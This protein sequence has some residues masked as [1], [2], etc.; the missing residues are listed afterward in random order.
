[1]RHFLERNPGEVVIFLDEDFVKEPDL[2]SAYRRAGLMPYLAT[3]DR[4]KPLPTLRQLIRS[5]RRVIVFTERV[6]S[7]NYPW[8][9]EG[10]SYIQDTPLGATKPTQFSCAPNRGQ[11]DSPLFAMNNWIDRFPPPLSANRAILRESFL[12]RRARRCRRRRGL[13]PNLIAG[14]FYDQGKLIEAVRVLNGVANRR[15]AP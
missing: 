1:M 6:P 10:F 15:P 3:L 4:V 12:L 9:H 2:A 14:D 8:N 7:G 11:P 5:N 13:L